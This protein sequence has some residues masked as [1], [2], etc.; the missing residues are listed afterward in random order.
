MFTKAKGGTFSDFSL[1]LFLFLFFTFSLFLT[2]VLHKFSTS[3]SHQF[4]YKTL[5]D[6]S[7][8]KGGYL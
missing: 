5:H 3:L 7:K 6:L 4:L 1:S 2:Q 8:K